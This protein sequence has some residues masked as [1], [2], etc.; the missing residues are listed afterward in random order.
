MTEPNWTKRLSFS[1]SWTPGH[2]RRVRSVG[3]LRFTDKKTRDWESMVALYAIESFRGPQIVRPC[4]VGLV[5]L[6]PMPTSQNGLRDWR[7]KR[8]LAETPDY[9]PHDGTPDIDTHTKGVL[10]G[11]NKSEVW[12]D[13]AQVSQIAAAKWWCKVSGDARTEITVWEMA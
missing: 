1:I 10:D 9:Y 8:G 3:A 13:D 6:I 4:R 2:W 11:L 7:K 5:F 12:R